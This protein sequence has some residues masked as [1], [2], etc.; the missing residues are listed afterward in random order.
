[1]SL[2]GLYPWAPRLLSTLSAWCVML[3]LL[4]WALADAHLYHSREI[5][6]VNSGRNV[7]GVVGKMCAGLPFR[8]FFED[9]KSIASTSPS[10]PP[11]LV[12]FSL[13]LFYSIRFPSRSS[14]FWSRSF[15][16]LPLSL[17]SPSPFPLS[18]LSLPLVSY[19]L[20]PS[21]SLYSPPLPFPVSLPSHFLPSRPALLLIPALFPVSQ[22]W[23]EEEEREVRGESESPQG[24]RRE[25]E[26][27]EQEEGE[28]C[29]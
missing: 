7:V 27:E 20:A 13:V 21:I 16:F 4:P 25:G 18:C 24:E 8:Q 15:F 12:G 28:R 11:S 2:G 1:M 19:H 23:G 10:L 5:N 3:T 6:K 17:F 9:Y 22:R 26:K 14:T 29:W